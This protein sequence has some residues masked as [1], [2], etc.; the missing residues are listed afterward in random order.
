MTGS[1]TPSLTLRLPTTDDEAA[2]WELNRSCSTA[3]FDF[4]AG[5]GNLNADST[6][7]TAFLDSVRNQHEGTDLPEGWLPADFLVAEVITGDGGTTL[8]GRTSIRY[9]LNEYLLNYGGHIGYAVAPPTTIVAA[10]PPRSSGSPS[11]CS[12][13]GVSTGPCSSVTMTTP[14]RSESSKPAVAS[15]RTVVPTRTASLSAATGSRC[16]HHPLITCGTATAL[17]PSTPNSRP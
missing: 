7:Y 5:V 12:L 1:T 3:T 13:S 15:S 14:A 11:P 10:T 2:V 8:I 9:G 16:E 6:G 17:S 4:L